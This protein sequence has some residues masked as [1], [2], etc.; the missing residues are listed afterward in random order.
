MT[1]K[2]CLARKKEINRPDSDFYS[3]P[4]SLVWVVK[5]IILR[6]FD[7]NIN[8]LE[9]GSGE[10]AIAEE[11]TKYG[12]NITTNDIR[13]DTDTDCHSD[14]LNQTSLDTY[15]YVI[16]NPPF[17]LWDKFI[18]KSKEHCS[19]FMVIGKSDYLSAHGRNTT[20]LWDHLKH[21]YIFDRKVDFQTPYRTDGKF[22]LGMLNAAWFL[23][24]MNY[25]GDIKT[26]VV[27]V[28]DYAKLGPYNKYI[29]CK[30]CIGSECT[31]CQGSGRILIDYNSR[32]M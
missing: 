24:D 29:K 19:K 12:Y 4:K 21:I 3:T 31:L 30:K 28:N 20:G 1:G 11:L 18:L 13:I 26:S 2:N 22:H 7:N 9:P 14:Y 15:K 32:R 25:L 8:I 23:F 16:T 6:E 27:D 10:N 5:D 17:S